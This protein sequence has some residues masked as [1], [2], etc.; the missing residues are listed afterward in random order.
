MFRLRRQNPAS[1]RLAARTCLTLFATAVVIPLAPVSVPAQDQ[2]IRRVPAPGWSLFGIF[3]PGRERRAQPEPQRQIERAPSQAKRKSTAEA[4]PR[5]PKTRVV[6]A[7]VAAEPEVVAVEKASDAR[8]IVVVGDFLASG[9]AEGLEAIFADNAKVRVIDRSKGNSGLV[10]DDVYDW[11]QEIAG[12]IEAEKPAALA[13]LL[14][15]NDRQPLR[16]EGES[17]SVRSDAWTKE[18]ERRTTALAETIESKKTPFVWV[19]VPAFKSAKMTSDMLAFNMVYKVSAQGG[20]GEFV[21]VWDG[22]VDEN[23]AF[24]MVGPDVN[25]QPVKLRS[26]EGINLTSAGK[27]KLAF[28]AEK[29]LRKLLGLTPDDS[30]AP[31]IAAPSLETGPVKPTDVDRTEPIALNDPNLDGGTE[32]LGG[33][34]AKPATPFASAETAVPPG[35]VDNFGGAVQ[36][37]PVAG[38]AGAA[39]TASGANS[40]AR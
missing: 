24:V 15:S 14:G 33:A 13:V 23:G 4:Q 5:K 8:S 40:A 27:A 38:P 11:P 6:P 19:S 29:P 2:V 1:R 7:A 30:P 10:R 26:G 17:Q 37:P 22:F 9:L 21:D 31:K 25:G 35:R 39:S 3:G 32:L 18:Y 28:Y 20:G 12:L 36:A 34:E 16:V